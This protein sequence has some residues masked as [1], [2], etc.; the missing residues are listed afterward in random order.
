MS[1]KADD[2]LKS[3]VTQGVSDV[4]FKVGRPTLLRI[5][6][7]LQTC[8]TP[9]LAPQDTEYL[10]ATFLGEKRWEK[11]QELSEYD[12]S[13]AIPGFSRFRVNV[14][15]QR[16]TISLVLRV[17]PFN[18]P[19]I[20]ELGVPPVVKQL[21]LAP[22]G[23]ILVT[24]ATGTGKSSTLAGMINHVNE[25]RE[26]HVITIEDPI[27]FLHR[28]KKASINQRE[29]GVDTNNFNDAFRA[30]LRQDPDIILVG[31]LRDLETMTIALRAAE[32]GHLVMSTLHTTDAKETIG[33]FI[34]TF[35]PHQH[36][37]VR[38]QLAAN[39][40]AV[41]SQRL[42]RRADG[43]GLVLAAEIM[44]VNAAIREYIADE[45]KFAEIQAHIE[46]GR[47]AYGMQTFDQALFDLFK[48]G[49]VSAEEAI[50]NATSP[51]DFRLRLNFEQQGSV[52]PQ[53]IEISS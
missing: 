28:D 7:I 46:K 16:G 20:D 2:F 32:T 1:S 43:R 37:Q 9:P 34:D 30:A 12:T 38:M 21:A 19:T 51:N 29:V 48:R 11:F 5:N 47:E 36:R 24:G 6:G 39:L 23:L 8:N 4:H 49:V 40:R 22:R 41:V 25:H 18:V 31:E 33:R 26:C 27:E 35:P 52:V 15:R 44:V 3:I 53:G 45:S 42:L 17:I 50:R 14:F 13:Y 10:A